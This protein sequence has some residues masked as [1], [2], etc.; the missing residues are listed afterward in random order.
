[1]PIKVK[2]VKYKSYSGCVIRDN[3]TIYPNPQTNLHMDRAVYL[4]SLLETAG[5]FG[6]VQSY[7][8]CAMSAGLEHNVSVLPRT[9]EQGGLFPALNF[10]RMAVPERACPPLISLLGAFKSVGW[11]LDASGVLRDYK[12]GQKVS[13]QA[14]RNEFTPD[15]GVVPETGP[16]WEQAK[17]WALLYNALFNHSATF[18]T[19]IESAKRSLLLG[20][21]A[22]EISAYK[23]ICGVEYPAILMINVNLTPEQDLAMC[24]YHS[25]SVNAPSIARSCL[26][27]SKPDNTPAWPKRLVRILGTRKYGNWQDTAT[28][29][30]RYDRTRIYAK[31][32]GMWPA[33]LFD[34]SG[35]MPENVA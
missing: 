9:M 5:H 12:T 22:G 1:M 8:S 18:H 31:N 11:V 23:A 25:H 14:I 24:V 6:V 28:G 10:I 13:G 30:S 27:E 7:D 15:N 21:K 17:R 2:W 19:Q 20:N 16:K 26:I 4:T 29:T 3:V 34:N 32:S 33:T 35:I